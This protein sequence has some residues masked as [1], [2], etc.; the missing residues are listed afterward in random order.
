L[1]SC[2][3]LSGCRRIGRRVCKRKEGETVGE[4]LTEGVHPGGD[5]PWVPLGSRLPQ[6]SL[7]PV[8]RQP[9]VTS[10]PAPVC[11]SGGYRSACGKS[12]LRVGCGIIP[13]CGV[14]GTEWTSS[15]S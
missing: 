5:R 10:R 15:Y 7:V 6:E 4:I 1:P 2:E 13:L 11:P 3:L 9:S 14:V 12:M 8:N